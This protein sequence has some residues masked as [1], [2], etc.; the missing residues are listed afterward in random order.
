MLEGV[1]GI[2]EATKGHLTFLA[3]PR[4]EKYLATTGASAVVV[5]E[6]H[7]SKALGVALLA[8]PREDRLLPA[9]MRLV[10]ASRPR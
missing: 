6:E 2:K 9:L 5:G 7:R 1:A 8:G 4:Y 10:P 3:N